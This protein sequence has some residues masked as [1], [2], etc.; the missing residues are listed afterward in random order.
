VVPPAGVWQLGSVAHALVSGAGYE[1]NV[2]RLLGLEAVGDVPAPCQVWQIK[3][4][5]R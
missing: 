4:L 1:R 2:G 5:S 3:G